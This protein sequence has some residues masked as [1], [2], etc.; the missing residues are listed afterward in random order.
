MEKSIYSKYSL[1]NTGYNKPQSQEDSYKKIIKSYED[2][3]KYEEELT[4][5]INYIKA[6]RLVSDYENNLLEAQNQD[7]ENQINANKLKGEDNKFKFNFD[8]T[9]EAFNPYYQKNQKG[10]NNSDYSEIEN[11]IR[12]A[13][14]E[15][16]LQERKRNESAQEVTNL[17]SQY[18]VTYLPQE[19][20]GIINNLSTQGK[21]NDPV[22]SNFLNSMMMSGNNNTLNQNFG[23]R[24]INNNLTSD[25]IA[26]FNQESKFPG[27]LVTSTK[28][29]SEKKNLPPPQETNSNVVNKLP[30]VNELVNNIQTVPINNK[31]EKN[32]NIIPI[33]E[34]DNNTKPPQEV[35]ANQAF[36][37]KVVSHKTIISPNG[38]TTQTVHTQQQ[39]VISSS[40]ETTAN[41]PVLISEINKID[42]N[43]DALKNQ[44]EMQIQNPM[45]NQA[46]VAQQTQGTN[47]KENVNNQATASTIQKNLIPKT[48]VSN[49]TDESDIVYEGKYSIIRKK[50]DP[51]VEVDVPLKY[52][53]KPIMACEIKPFLDINKKMVRDKDNNILFLGPNNTLMTKKD[54]DF[55]PLDGDDNFLVNEKNKLL[56]GY[57][58]VLLLDEMLEPLASNVEPFDFNKKAFIKG[59]VAD[60][61]EGD[62]KELA[63]KKKKLK[64]KGGTKG[65]KKPGT[66]K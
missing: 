30:E 63:D 16:L 22:S 42:S 33:Q 13:Q 8:F 11:Q 4:E 3:K 43:I 44:M 59:S 47:L 34:S 39:K 50:V 45:I 6:L 49:V 65:K 21:L 53:N 15:V 58:G 32:V 20:M 24:V 31:T 19:T 10:N 48:T 36:E 66:K 38:T 2:E 1:G 51:E 57:K 62:K 27:A 23:D 60:F 37:T 12:Q 52:K 64:K 14:N 54:L 5:R 28:L 9:G 41:K 55:I 29:K 17:G 18:G 40:E 35:T 56:Y 46:V 7:L 26:S 61:A 25:N